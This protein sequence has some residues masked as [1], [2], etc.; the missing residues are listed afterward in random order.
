VLL[1][2]SVITLSRCDKCGYEASTAYLVRG[3][4]QPCREWRDTSGPQVACADT[5]N[6][7]KKLPPTPTVVRYI[8]VRKALARAR[9]AYGYVPR[10]V[11][12]IVRQNT[13]RSGAMES[14]PTTKLP[15]KLHSDKMRKLLRV[16]EA[17]ATLQGQPS[18]TG[19]R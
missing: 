9:A 8:T 18:D 5:H 16:K 3:R 11:T 14:F 7:A 10:F 13:K 1:Q 12:T 15:T 19:Q 4:C 2:S 17:T 6:K